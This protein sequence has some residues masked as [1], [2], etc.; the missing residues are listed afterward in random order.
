MT[1]EI[2]FTREHHIGLVTLNRPQALNALTLTMILALQEQLQAWQDDASI[3]AVVVRSGG[4]RAFCAGGDVR[5]I[6]HHGHENHQQKME[7]FGNEYRLNRYIHEYKKPYIAL[8][9]GIT[10]GGGVGISLHGS[11]PVATER[12]LFAM[13][14]TGIGFYPDIGASYLLSRCP[15]HFGVYLGLT[16]SRLDAVDAH[17]LGLVKYIIAGEQCPAVLQSLVE[18]DLSRDAH[19]VVHDVLQS[20]IIPVTSSHIDE[21][22][23]L[24]NACFQYDTIESILKALESNPGKWQQETLETLAKKAPLSL[25]VTLAQLQRAKSMTITECLQMDYGLTSHFMRNTDF[26]E[27][28]RALLVDKDNDPHWRPATLSGATDKM[29]AGYFA[30]DEF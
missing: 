21:W 2:L 27:G 5:A 29:V 10:M 17:A 7:F 12:F 9:D 30:G 4:G 20:F 18:A 16:G 15:G 14:E 6:Y 23:P 11:H 24:V 8:M 13:P 25:K 1:E 22:A 28:V 26:H 19:Q 3:H